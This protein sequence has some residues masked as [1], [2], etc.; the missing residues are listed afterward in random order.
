MSTS[1][2]MPGIA[3]FSRGF[4][5]MYSSSS[6]S[7]VRTSSP[8]TTTSP[9]SAT[10]SAAGVSS[11]GVSSAG[12]SSATGVSSASAAGVSS[13]ASAAAA[14]SAA[15]SSGSLT[16][17]S[18]S[19][20]GKS[21]VLLLALDQRH[22][23]RLLRRVRMVGTRVDLQLG[24]LLARKAVARQHALDRQPDDFLG[25]ALQHV[26]QRAGL[27]AARV[28]RVA[29]VHLLR[30]L[31]AGRSE[32]RRVGKEC[33]SRW[34][35][36]HEKKNREWRRVVGWLFRVRAWNRWAKTSREE[37]LGNTCLEEGIILTKLILLH[38]A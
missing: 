26:V 24:E 27:Q 34:S 5:S 17:S 6:S 15:R 18:F 33:R 12:A 1:R 10:G 25:A 7:S 2:S 28:T 29:V 11:A 19:A 37:N 4:S 16:W 9:A 36:Y 30:P 31:L 21:L 22:R 32:E 20:M 14:F 3:G 38:V 23:L 8:S 13:A 35:A